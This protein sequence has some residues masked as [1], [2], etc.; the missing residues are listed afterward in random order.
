M[1]KN[2]KTSLLKGRQK[3]FFLK[4]RLALFLLIAP[5][6]LFAQEKNVSLQIKEMKIEQAI[7]Q[8]RKTTDYKFLFNHEEVKNA[9]SKTLD[10]KNVPLESVLKALLQGTNLTYRIEKNVV[11]IIPVKKQSTGKPQRVKISGNVLDQNQQPIPGV[12][13]INSATKEGITTDM[14]GNFTLDIPEDPNTILIFSMLG[15]KRQEVTIGGQRDLKITM[16]EDVVQLGDVIVTGYQTLSKER[17]AG[18]FSVVSGNDISEKAGLTGDIMESME[19]LTTGL[20][21]SYSDGQ[22]KYLIRGTTSINSNRSPLFVVDGVSMT[23]ESFENLVNS[24]DI[25]NITF[26]KDATAASIW[27]AQAAN[28]VVVVTTKQGKNTDEKIKI[29]Y[30]G[31]YTY[32]G[33]PDYD[34]MQYMSSEQFMKSALE[35]FD[36]EFYTWNSVTTTN[37]G[38]GGIIPIVYPHEEILYK[39]V[40][41]ESTLAERDAALAQM[42]SR[43]NR[44]QIEKNFMTPAYFTTHSLSFSGGSEK[45]RYYGSLAYEHNTSSN[46]NTSNKYQLNL[47]Q[48]FKFTN[49]LKIDLGINMAMLDAKDEVAPYKTDLNSILP[50]QMFSDE[51]GNP[52]S[53]AGLYF[54]E[55]NRLKYE[56]QS[57]KS[58][59]YVPLNDSKNSFQ[60]NNNFSA[61]INAGLNIR[62]IDGLSYDGRFQY[63]RSHGKNELFYDQNSIRVREELVQFTSVKNGSPE[64][65]LPSSGGYYKTG[66]SLNTSWTVR[67]QLMF[68]RSFEASES[69]LTALA[70]VEI[71]SDRTNTQGTSARG[72]NPQA[73]TYISYDEKALST[74]GVAN[75]VLPTS[76]T[77]KNVLNGKVGSYSETEMRFVSLY[78]NGAYTWQA[79]YSLNA[80]IRVDQSNLFGSDPSVQFKPIWAAGAAWAMS[81][82]GFLKDIEVLNRLN[83]R[84]SY[85]LGGNSPDPGLGGP[86]DV[87]YPVSNNLYA[88][89]GQGYVIITPANDK[90]S[91]E[92][93]RIINGGVDFAVLNHRLSGAVDIYF[94]KTTD[95]LGEI[96]LHPASGWVKSLANLGTMKNSGVELSLNSQNIKSKYFNWRS[97][98]TLTYNKNKITELYTADGLSASSIIN[99]SFVEG[100]TAQS[101][102]A[103]RWAGLDKSGDPQIY[104]L[105][106]EKIKLAKDL[107]DQDLDA[108]DCAGSMQPEWYG[109][110][111]NTFSYKG[112]E[113]SFMFIY[114]LG[115]K[116]RN[117]RNKFYNGRLTSN[118]HRDFDNR[119]RKEGDEQLT[120]VPAYISNN[121]VSAN[122]REMDF[123]HYADV[124][125]LNASYIKLR[126]LTLSWS[127][128]KNICN[129]LATENI[130]IRLQAANLFYWAANK[131]GID[132]ESFNL[133]YGNRATHYGPS[134]SVGLAVNFK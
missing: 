21:V 47:K 2:R 17:S 96:P 45:H 112:L 131:E 27:G 22:D 89:L 113:L 75:P 63:Q 119:W 30:N 55:P 37:S 78:A 12:A 60:N 44:K 36:P 41:G 19:G 91:W 76:S 87:M 56:Q 102:F 69:Q 132:P 100:Y 23:S 114:N 33:L 125:I 108:V 46:R 80:S 92:K 88:D 106:D 110:L 51:K 107:Q 25:E 49:W 79:K 24:N 77:G 8:L 93:T 117:D 15:M 97:D 72:Y 59:D 66:N 128:P 28:G 133:K 9:G 57:Q 116:M 7:Q 121:K 134:Y 105:N 111:T 83:L 14:D 50:Y 39:Y 6:L 26:L 73:M 67:N 32:K 95:L 127:L 18:A 61:R 90:L 54:Y 3:G 115:H 81:Q 38:I 68:D 123:Y 74:T 11:V 62:L 71:R 43:N 16:E 31:S 120:N 34:Y 42:A 101:L 64:Y 94:K 52:L 4:V 48:D 35:I 118:I 130:K 99:Q 124:N 20:S 82:E 86:Y 126:D 122:R 5:A 29:S 13:V 1:K 53:H 85:G 109:G 103:Y 98:F 70:G 58:L 84:F 104:N 65:Y 40:N 129:R 10:L